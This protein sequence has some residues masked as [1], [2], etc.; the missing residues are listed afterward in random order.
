MIYCDIL[1]YKATNAEPPYKAGYQQV[2]AQ[3][4]PYITYNISMLTKSIKMWGRMYCNTK[5]IQVSDAAA[6][7]DNRIFRTA[8]IWG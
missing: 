1:Q 2:R 3:S 7:R 8:V 6:Q 5:A 4:E